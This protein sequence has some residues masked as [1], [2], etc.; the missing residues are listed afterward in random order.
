MK[1]PL[2]LLLLLS[3]LPAA[4]QNH[5]NSRTKGIGTN[6]ENQPLV[7]VKRY[8]ANP[9]FDRSIQFISD[10]KASIYLADVEKLDGNV[11]TIIYAATADEARY[12]ESKDVIPYHA[13]FSASKDDYAMCM[14]Q[15]TDSCDITWE[16]DAF[17]V[18]NKKDGTQRKLKPIV[19]HK[20][21]RLTLNREDDRTLVITFAD[22]QVPINQAA[23]DEEEYGASAVIAKHNATLEFNSF[24]KGKDASG[25]VTVKELCEIG[26]A[27]IW[28][29]GENLLGTDA[30]P[31]DVVVKDCS[32]EGRIILKFAAD[33]ELFLLDEL[34][35]TG[36]LAK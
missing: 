36:Y 12:L 29:Q 17:L 9:Q 28:S 11:E 4:C 18:A 6:L 35:V 25:M 32:Q 10:M 23:A 14:F 13:S 3:L 33:K 7:I 5:E 1:F 8:K 21:T 27:S 15:E 26:Q 22:K 34:N 31:D 20:R 2:G 19:N 30:F 24:S 16:D